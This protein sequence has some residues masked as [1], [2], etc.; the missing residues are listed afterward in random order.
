MTSRWYAVQVHAGREKWVASYFGDHGLDYLL[1]LR[2]EKR[3]WTDR[4]KI[5]EIPLFTGYVFCRF[6]VQERNTVLSAP[7]TLRLVGCGRTPL[8]IAEDEIAA[9][10]ILEKSEYLLMEWPYLTEGDLVC[11]EGGALEGLLGRVVRV[12]G[13]YRVVVSVTIMQRS[14]AIEVDRSR[15]RLV[16]A[17]ARSQALT[18]D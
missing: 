6:N 3:R 16:T 7:G 10:Q 1:L 18:L 14:V 2:R 9:L 4:S 12:Q 8:P 15:L 13:G 17:D 11:L 5:I